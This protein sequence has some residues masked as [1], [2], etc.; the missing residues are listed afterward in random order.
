MWSASR[1]R[2][3]PPGRIHGTNAEEKTPG[4]VGRAAVC[5]LAGSSRWKVRDSSRRLLQ[6]IFDGRGVTRGVVHDVRRREESLTDSFW[7][8]SFNQLHLPGDFKRQ[9]QRAFGGFAADPR[10]LLFA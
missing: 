3:H 9:I 8:G 5:W 10:G 6:F 4:S 7:V 2:L 1:I